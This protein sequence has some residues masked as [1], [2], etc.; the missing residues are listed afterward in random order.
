[1][2][3]FHGTPFEMPLVLPTQGPWG[4][5]MAKACLSEAEGMPML[6][7]VDSSQTF[8][9]LCRL[10]RVGMRGEQDEQVTQGHG[11]RG[12]KDDQPGPAERESAR[13]N[14]NQ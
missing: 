12:A 11:Q 5:L 4:Q 6:R 10:V 2:S 8:S 7:R 1:M 3:V 14:G 9:D 13:L